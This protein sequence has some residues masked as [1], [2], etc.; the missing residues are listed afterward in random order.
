MQ[1]T[2][3]LVACNGNLS[4]QMKLNLDMAKKWL[5]WHTLA[6]KLLVASNGNLSH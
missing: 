1:A 3:F 4:H 2:K 5:D 6:S